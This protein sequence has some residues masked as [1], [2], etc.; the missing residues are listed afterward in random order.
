MLCIITYPVVSEKSMKEYNREKSQILS[1]D[2]Y[3]NSFDLS[4]PQGGLRDPG[5][6]HFDYM[7]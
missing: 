4:S 7:M 1:W 5:V 2:D 6:P 3:E